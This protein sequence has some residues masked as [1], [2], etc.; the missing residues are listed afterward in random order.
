MKF[1][2]YISEALLGTSLRGKKAS[3]RPLPS[4]VPPPQL[5]LDL[6]SLQTL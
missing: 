4:I 1:Y 2:I 6:K 3:S 5:V